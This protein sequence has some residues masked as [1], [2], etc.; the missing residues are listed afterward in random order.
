MAL[1]GRF[2]R[3]S[4]VLVDG[5]QFQGVPQLHFGRKVEKSKRFLK[6]WN[7]NVFGIVAVKKNLALSQVDFW[8]SEELQGTLSFE[9]EFTKE[10]SRAEYDKWVLM[11]ETRWRQKSRESF[12]KEADRN[13]IFFFTKWQM[14]IGGGIIWLR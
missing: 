7:I 14:H 12:L 3:C 5:P 11:E 8:D 9:E 10:A 1:G 2:Q 6:R 4:E 13:T